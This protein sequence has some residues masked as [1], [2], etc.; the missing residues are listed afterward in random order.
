MKIAYTKPS[1]TQ[2]EVDYA[3]DA[4]KMVGEK[5]ATII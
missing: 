1:I 5:I 2:L 4:P 3:A